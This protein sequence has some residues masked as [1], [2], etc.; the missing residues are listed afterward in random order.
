LVDNST[1]FT[2]ILPVYNEV[3]CIGNTIKECN[4]YVLQKFPGASCIIVEDGSTDGTTQVLQALAKEINFVLLSTKQK[5]GYAIAV[6]DALKAAE[7]DL[8]FF[9]DSDGQYDFRD[10]SIFLNKIDTYDIVSGYRI[11]RND[12][13]MRLVFSRAYNFLINILFGVSF[14]DINS[15]FKLIKKGVIDCIREEWD[16]LDYCPMTEL[17]LRAHAKGFKIKETAIRHHGRKFG[18]TVIFS[19]QKLPRIIFRI[20][21]GMMVIRFSCRKSNQR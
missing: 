13:V 4:A 10:I 3:G 14:N 2:L 21:H 18:S 1:K 6:R 5:K 19:P 15:G 20:L 11:V 9:S 17:L 8:V 12:N 16:T 7:T